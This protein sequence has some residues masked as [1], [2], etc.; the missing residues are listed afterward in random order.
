MDVQLFPHHLLNVPSLFHCTTFAFV[1]GQMAVS[2]GSTSGLSIMCHSSIL[3]PIQ[4]LFFIN[5]SC[6]NNTS[7]NHSFFACSI[8]CFFGCESWIVKKA[9]R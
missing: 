6:T 3:I 7:I 9:E 1:R 4:N 5:V 8:F 2:C